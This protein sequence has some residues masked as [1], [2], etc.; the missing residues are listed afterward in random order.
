MFGFRAVASCTEA[1]RARTRSRARKKTLLKEHVH[2]AAVMH[3]H[4]RADLPAGSARPSRGH[5]WQGLGDG[6]AGPRAQRYPVDVFARPPRAVGGICDRR[7]GWHRPVLD[8][9]DGRLFADCAGLK[10]GGRHRRHTS[11]IGR[12]RLEVQLCT[13]KRVRASQKS[14]SRARRVETS[15]QYSPFRYERD[16]GSKT[17]FRVLGKSCKLAR[18]LEPL[19]AWRTSTDTA[20]LRVHPDVMPDKGRE[21][22]IH[23]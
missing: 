6:C 18:I 14:Q 10:P 13:H 15:S 11:S 12:L 21:I 23:R 4:R 5:A 19:D 22:T 2:R 8:L 16:V 3:T 20:L 1:L 7:L 9:C 17:T